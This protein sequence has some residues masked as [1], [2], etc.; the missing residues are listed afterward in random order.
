[1]VAVKLFKQD[2]SDKDYHDHPI[3]G[4]LPSFLSGDQDHA[5]IEKRIQLT[6]LNPD[7]SIVKA[8]WHYQDDDSQVFW[9]NR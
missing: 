5:N 4:Y 6:F 8:G 9:L 7:A 3:T 1:M 2:D